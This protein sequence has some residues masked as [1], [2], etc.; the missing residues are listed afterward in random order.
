[1]KF[2]T[3]TNLITDLKFKQQVGVKADAHVE[4]LAVINNHEQ[5]KNEDL[6]LKKITDESEKLQIN[7]KLFVKTFDCDVALEAVQCLKD[8]LGKSECIKHFIYRTC[9]IISYA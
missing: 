9:L 6:E 1:M 7:A 2:L 3:S 8:A 4:A 5:F